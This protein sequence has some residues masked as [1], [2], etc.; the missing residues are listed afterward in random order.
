MIG[1]TR[2]DKMFDILTLTNNEKRMQFLKDRKEEQGW[3]DWKI[4]PEVDRVFKRVEI[5]K[6]SLI[7]E[8]ETFSALYPKPHIAT[9]ERGV[10][11]LPDGE[12]GNKLFN[13]YS[14]TNS[15]VLKKI[16]Q[17]QKSLKRGN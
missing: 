16:Q 8:V 14:T 12:K 5:G 9:V 6:A 1:A 17:Y 10:W 15:E 2:R 4:I 11:Y 7:V 3:Y 13:S